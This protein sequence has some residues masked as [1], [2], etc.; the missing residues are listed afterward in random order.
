MKHYNLNIDSPFFIDTADVDYVKKTIDKLSS[1]NVN[2]QNLIGVTTNP[3]ALAKINCDTVE[4]LV[5]VV[6]Q[7]T[8]LVT[9]VRNDNYGV[10]YVQLPNSHATENE[11]LTWASMLTQ[12]GDGKTAVGLKIPPYMQ[13]LDIVSN[14]SLGK[15]IELNVTGV[16]DAATAFRCL[17][18]PDIAFVSVIPGRMEE[19][20]I[21]ASAHLKLIAQRGNYETEIIAGSMRTFDGLR[22]SIECGTVPTIG[23]RVF[24]SMTDAEYDEFSNLWNFSTCEADYKKD[25]IFIDERNHKLTIDFFDQMDSLGTSLYTELKAASV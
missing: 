7:L 24:D 5:D 17:S 22:R 19:V 10:V 11:I 2:M 8:K 6:D 18:Y 25:L 23:S 14:M 9:S 15:R 3:N 21:D 20:G 13:T 1:H 4:K 12:I 16:S